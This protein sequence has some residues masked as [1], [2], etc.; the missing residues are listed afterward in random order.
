[1]SSDIRTGEKPLVAKLELPVRLAILQPITST[2]SSGLKLTVGLSEP[3]ILD[4]SD[5]LMLEIRLTGNVGGGKA[6]ATEAKNGKSTRCIRDGRL[7]GQYS[8]FKYYSPTLGILVGVV[9]NGMYSAEA[10]LV[11]MPI[12]TGTQRTRNSDFHRGTK[13]TLLTG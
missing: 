1:M 12:S 9:G 13:R 5:W 8:G 6:A 11:E 10:G 2:F 4:Q 3:V 7:L